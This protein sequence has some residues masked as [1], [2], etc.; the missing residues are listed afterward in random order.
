MVTLPANAAPPATYLY[1][2]EWMIHFGLT[3]ELLGQRMGKSRVTIWRWR[4]DQKRLNPEKI[5]ALAA[6]MGIEPEDLWRPPSRPS[7]DAIVK[8]ATDELVNKLADVAKIMLKK[9]GT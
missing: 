3:D 7:L 5:A 8:N 6:A 4:T 2:D 1:I 9:T